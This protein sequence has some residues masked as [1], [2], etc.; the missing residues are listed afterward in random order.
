MTRSCSPRKPKVCGPV[1]AILT[2]ATCLGTAHAAETEE[3]VFA[4]E[5]ALYGA[6]YEI[7]RADGWLDE[8]LRTAIRAY[9]TENNLQISGNLNA[10]TLEALGVT[11]I[12]SAPITS[13]AVGSRKESVTE[14]GLSFPEPMRNTPAVARTEPKSLPQPEPK[15]TPDPVQQSA[16][17]IQKTAVIDHKNVQEQ[18]IAKGISKPSEV[19]EV[20]EKTVA[21][22]ATSEPV[23]SEPPTPDPLPE[24]VIV[25]STTS[26]TTEEP[27]PVLAQLPEEPTSAG[28]EE[29]NTADTKKPQPEPANT[30][31]PKEP[32]VT[33][34][35]RSTG[36]GFF[37]TLFD[38]FFGWL[39]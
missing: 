37:S 16:E 14:L 11:K 2:A 30:I 18:G 10:A 3:V 20:K 13:N 38:F 25:A 23:A 9:Q 39:V 32:E 22:K 27:D 8:Q 17:P 34:S 1:I 26:E 31:A 33:E 36:G 4:A 19:K 5:N 15:P 7:G 12:P 35:P 24:P 21:E 6:G 29:V 28:Y